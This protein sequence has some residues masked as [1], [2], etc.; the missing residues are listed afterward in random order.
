[1]V[2]IETPRSPRSRKHAQWEKWG[3]LYMRYSG[4]LLLILIFGHIFINLFSGEGIKQID[5]AFV[6]GKWASPFWQ[7]YDVLM[8]WLALIH[9][10]NG[11]R[12]IV[13]DYTERETVRKVLNYTLWIVCGLLIVLGTLVCVTFDPCIDQAMRASLEVCKG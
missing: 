9:G 4:A 11:M 8:L 12:T 5:F 1:M 13:N 7:V 6:A 2:T 10:T 3:W